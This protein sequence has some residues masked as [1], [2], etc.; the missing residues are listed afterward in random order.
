MS[1]GVLSFGP[2][3][4]DGAIDLIDTALARV[5]EATSGFGAAQNRLAAIGERLGGKV[6]EL[7]S[8]ES[9]LREADLGAEATARAA[10]V[11]RE[12]VA[13]AM[14]A[15]ENAAPRRLLDLLRN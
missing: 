11:I 5:R 2:G 10:A 12:Q 1:N 7:S 6:V 15:H 3:P 4:P 14:S 8:A 9:V 13:M